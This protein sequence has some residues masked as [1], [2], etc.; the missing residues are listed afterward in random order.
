[1]RNHRMTI[2][3]T[4]HQAESK[5]ILVL[6]ALVLPRMT[7]RMR[8]S[9]SMTILITKHPLLILRMPNSST[10]TSFSITTN[11]YARWYSVRSSSLSS[12]IWRRDMMAPL[13]LL[14]T[15]LYQASRC[16][17]TVKDEVMCPIFSMILGKEV[18]TWYHNFF[19]WFDRGA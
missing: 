6:L 10:T 4:R 14:I 11:Y 1:M 17:P 7:N 13:I 16:L 8:S 15:S 2:V 5:I 9:S 19:V 12:L 3:S 18:H